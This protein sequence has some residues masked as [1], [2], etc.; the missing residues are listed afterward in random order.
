MNALTLNHELPMKALRISAILTVLALLSACG[1]NMTTRS[2][3]LFSGSGPTTD[4]ALLD[5][6]GA[7]EAQCSMFDSTSTRLGGRVTTYYY[8]GTLQE[9]KVRVRFTSL[10]ENFDSN[11]NLYIQMFR[12]KIGASGTAE[13]DSTPVQFQFEK[14]TGSAS[15]ISTLATSISSAGVASMRS[16]HGIAGTTSLEFFAN[17]TMVVNAVDYNWHALKVVMYDGSTSPATVV[18]QADFLLP[19]F[20]ANPNRYALTHSSILNQIHPFYSQRATSLSEAGWA[21]RAQSYCF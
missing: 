15:P 17:T 12:W 5:S 13:I 20:H 10:N 8:D 19:I 3:A 2:T 18:G 1:S 16:A 4:A 14:G 9:D 21:A 11:S 6:S 7:G